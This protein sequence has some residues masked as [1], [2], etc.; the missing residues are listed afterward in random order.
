MSRRANAIVLLDRG[1]SC[2]RV[3][4]AL[5][6]DDDTVRSWHSAYQRG[7]VEELKS[8]GHEGSGSHLSSEQEAALSEWVDAHCPHSIRKVGAWLRRSFGLSYSRSGLI[9]LL[10]RLGFDYRKPERMPR[11]LDDAKQQAFI[12]EYE[13]LL[14]EPS[15]YDG[16]R[17]GGR[18]RRCGS[19]D[20][21]G[22]TGRL[23][24]PQGRHDRGGADD[25][26]SA[27]EHPRRDQSGTGRTQI[28]EVET[29]DAESL[30]KLLGQVES[31]HPRERLIH[32]FVDNAKY[33]K[34]RIVQEWLAAAG[35]K[36]VL[37]FFPKYC[38]HLD[39]IERLWALMHE[40]VT[41]N[42]DYKTFS[43]LRAEIITFLR[44]TVPR[45]W[46]RFCD[47]ITDN[48]R[49]IHRANFRVLA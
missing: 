40:N 7:G 21:S 19:S 9:A 22:Q 48:F 31:A 14:N 45:H 24:G 12:D 47:R 3:A 34:A 49:V 46:S 8:F 35:R 6:L 37:R 20:P 32:V 44:Y 4:A 43:E 28:L 16:R 23:L 29:V 1:W 17:R 33:H 13:N 2:E 41:H 38:P 42:R 30:I 27:V 15:Q 26:P 25:G 36:C 11:G 10:H 39:P 5:L 18:L